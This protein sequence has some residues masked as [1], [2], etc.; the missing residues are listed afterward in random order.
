MS[1]SNT[2]AQ[3]MTKV[4]ASPPHRHAVPNSEL[5][6]WRKP[7]RGDRPT[8]ESLFSLWT[9]SGYTFGPRGEQVVVG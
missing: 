4:K 7:E 6:K 2:T 3:Q 5:L 8:K 1:Q 9:L